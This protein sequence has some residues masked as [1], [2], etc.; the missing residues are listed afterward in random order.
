MGR[1]EH[2]S[3]FCVEILKANGME[4]PEKEPITAN[5]GK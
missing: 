5:I 4:I 2:L 3:R 1:G